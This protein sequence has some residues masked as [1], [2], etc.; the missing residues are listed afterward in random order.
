MNVNVRVMLENIWLRALWLA[1]ALIAGLVVGICA[2][3]LA[4]ANGSSGP[5]SIMLGGAAFSGATVFLLSL[6][7]FLGAP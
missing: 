7:Q 3:V 4:C 1:F 6:V 2:G 5:K